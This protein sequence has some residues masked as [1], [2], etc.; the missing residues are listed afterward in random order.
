M[1]L[2]LDPYAMSY[3]VPFFPPSVRVVGANT[4]L[5]HPGSLGRLEERTEA[6]INGHIGPFWGLE[7]PKD[8]PGRADATLKYYGLERTGDCTAIKTNID[9]PITIACRIIRQPLS[10]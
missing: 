3:L 7:N 2:M 8:F 5:I 4:N 6:A 9:P 10:N 1:I